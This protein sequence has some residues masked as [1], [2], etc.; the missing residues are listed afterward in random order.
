SPLPCLW[1]QSAAVFSTYYH[2]VHSLVEFPSV[3]NPD[4]A[5]SLPGLPTLRP[6]ELP[7]FMLPS[8]PY[9][10]L[11]EVI[12]SQFRNIQKANWVLLNSFQELEHD[13]IK[14]LSDKLPLI[15]VGPLVDDNSN[16]EINGDLW[17]SAD[18]CVQ[19][20]DIQL[21]NSVVYVSLGSVVRLTETEM[22]EMANG[23]LNC[24]RPFLWV[25]RDD[26]R[27]LLPAEIMERVKDSNGML[28]SWSP[29]E[30]VLSHRSSGCFLTHCG[31]NSTLEALTA[32]C[33]VKVLKLLQ[34]TGSGACSCTR[35]T[36]EGPELG[37]LV[38]PRMIK[39]VHELEWKIVR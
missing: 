16:S 35:R 31:W 5:V 11:T 10:S 36:R 23:L 29:Q 25:V 4:V 26:C 19:W 7:T 33:G 14:S 34:M 15:P 38:V 8:N 22:T 13:A 12:L 37:F 1:V 39:S 30:K 6:D 32:G 24:G 21:P 28:V 9:K 17:K 18:D 27:K 20:L 2:Y 3:E